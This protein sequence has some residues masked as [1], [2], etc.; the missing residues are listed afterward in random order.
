MIWA[1][2]SQCDT[3]SLWLLSS[4]RIV[5]PSACVNLISFCA[6]K[7]FHAR[8][9]TRN[10]PH[11]SSLFHALT[12][13]E[14]TRFHTEVKVI[15]CETMSD[16]SDAVVSY[17]SLNYASLWHS[18]EFTFISEFFISS[19]VFPFSNIFS[20]SVSVSFSQCFFLP[21]HIF[22]LYLSVSIFLSVRSITGIYVILSRWIRPLTTRKHTDTTW[23]HIHSLVSKGTIQTKSHFHWWV[24][25]GWSQGH[26]PPLSGS[27][28]FVFM[29]FSAK[30]LQN[31]R[32]AQP[33][34]ELVPP[35]GKFRISHW[36]CV[37]GINP[38]LEQPPSIP[39][40]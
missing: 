7:L 5:C 40:G 23:R 20:L 11:H 13:K 32:L 8:A 37:L 25:G 33:L 16:K 12:R 22:S 34:R 24:G 28:C 14:K 27:N 21:S 26:A 35:S 3:G 30:N 10:V 29:Q 39:S 18:S 9:C 36:L 15:H 19:S 2:S 31:N 6:F 4:L 17:R 1:H 38:V